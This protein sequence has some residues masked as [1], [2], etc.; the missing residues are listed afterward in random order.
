LKSL[1]K[2]SRASARKIEKRKIGEGREKP[3]KC[4]INRDVYPLIVMK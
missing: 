2:K 4:F 1:K 3:K